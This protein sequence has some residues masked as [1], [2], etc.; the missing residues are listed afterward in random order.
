MLKAATDVD[1][2]E[3][4]FEQFF[5]FGW[6]R[7]EKRR[8]SGF[9]LSPLNGLTAKYDGQFD[10]VLDGP[11]ADDFCNNTCFFPPYRYAKFSDPQRDLK[12]ISDL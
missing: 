6:G 7:D 12:L 5:F 9:N 3:M 1:I 2:L 4:F 10:M 8:A 11:F